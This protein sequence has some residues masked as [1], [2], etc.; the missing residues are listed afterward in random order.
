M[1]EAIDLA[2]IDFQIAFSASNSWD[3]FETYDDPS[4]VEWYVSLIDNGKGENDANEQIIGT[5]TCTEEDFSKFYQIN[6]SSEKT[7]IDLKENNSFSCLD[8]TDI[9]GNE[10]DF[11]PY[12]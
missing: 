10:I 4:M 2:A 1:Q 12:G 7:F 6:I 11:R 9:N 3:I 8:K 5:H